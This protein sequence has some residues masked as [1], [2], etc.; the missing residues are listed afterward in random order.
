M[1]NYRKSFLFFFTEKKENNEKGFTLIELVIVIA[2]IGILASIGIQKYNEYKDKARIADVKLTLHDMQLAM[3]LL[4][5]DTNTWPGGSTPFICP[6][7]QTPS[8]DGAEYEDLTADDMGLF[9]NNGT[10]FANNGWNGPYLSSA[11]LDSNGNFVDPWGSPYFIDYDYRINGKEY[12]VIG[13]YGPNKGSK[14]SYDSDDV[15]LIVGY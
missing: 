7:N 10:T 11:R 12:A 15:Y 2:I 13:S 6:K 14:N 4:A 8:V 1:K 5:T 3:S 9:N